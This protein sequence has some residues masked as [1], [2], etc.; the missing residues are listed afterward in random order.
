M[1]LSQNIGEDQ[2]FLNESPMYQYILEGVNK[3]IN[4][5]THTHTHIYILIYIY[6]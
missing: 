4:T 1:R 3:H 5:H 6:R 2:D